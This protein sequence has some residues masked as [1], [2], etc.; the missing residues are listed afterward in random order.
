MAASKANTATA[1]TEEEVE[2]R[3]DAADGPLLDSAVASIKKL[4]ARG[5]ERGYVTYD[6]INAALPSPNRCRPSKS[7][8]PWRSSPRWA[9]T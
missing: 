1:A 4:L 8:T 7:K 3:D 2:Q 6:E 9:S 5:K